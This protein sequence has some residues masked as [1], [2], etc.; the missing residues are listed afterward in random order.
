MEWWAK[1][2]I[3]AGTY[4]L[5]QI[6]ETIMRKIAQYDKIYP[7]WANFVAILLT[8]YVIVS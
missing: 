8:A 4:I 2:L 7:Y 5:I 6:C 3:I 1:T